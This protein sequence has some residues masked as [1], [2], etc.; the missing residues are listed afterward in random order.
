[1]MDLM[2]FAEEQGDRG[3]GGGHPEGNRVM[4]RLLIL[5]I[6]FTNKINKMYNSRESIGTRARKNNFFKTS[7]GNNAARYNSEVAVQRKKYLISSTYQ[8]IK[9]V[10]I[11][12]MCLTGCPGRSP[13]T[14]GT[15]IETDRFS[16]T[17]PLP[18]STSNRP[19]YMHDFPS[20]P[21]PRDSSTKSSRT[22]LETSGS[23]RTTLLSSNGLRV[24]RRQDRRRLSAFRR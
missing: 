1:M 17:Q 22:E 10:K 16:P 15:I 4:I 18:S 6:P 13:T 7:L 2:Q 23:S 12:K 24:R 19:T 8:S 20:R 5:L 14:S 9:I 21:I 11:A 3:K